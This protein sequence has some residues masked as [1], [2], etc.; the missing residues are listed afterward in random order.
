MKPNKENNKAMLFQR[1]TVARLSNTDISQIFAGARG[2]QLAASEEE[3]CRASDSCQSYIIFP[4]CNTRPVDPV[5][6]VFNK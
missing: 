4:V 1:R 5:E 2:Q 3:R 6:Q